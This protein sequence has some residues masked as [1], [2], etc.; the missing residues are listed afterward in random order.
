M[1]V[2]RQLRAILHHRARRNHRVDSSDQT[3]TQE[4]QVRNGC[5]VY[6]VFH[7]SHFGREIARKNFNTLVGLQF[8]R[9]VV[10][11]LCSLA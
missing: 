11:I 8:I 3:A 9:N 5:D 2:L 6:R 4:I 10:N 1:C 7:V